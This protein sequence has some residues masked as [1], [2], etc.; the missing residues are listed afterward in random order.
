AG[1][2]AHW[3]V[4]LG[5]IAALTMT[6]GNVIAL[7]QTN[8]KRML[9]YSAIA[10]AGYLLVGMTAVDS[11]AGASV[12]YYLL[13]YAFTNLGAFGVVIALERR[14][15]ASDLISDYRG[16]SARAPALAGAMTIFLL[17]LV[18]VPP[19]AGVCSQFY[20]FFAAC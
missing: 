11:N 12:L 6:G 10:H 17:S 13:A 9:A 1:V 20:P 19:L 15:A 4:V 7:V 18:G 5:A 8:I 3:Q 14:G 2:S 16:L